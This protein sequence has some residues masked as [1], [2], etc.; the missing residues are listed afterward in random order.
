MSEHARLTADGAARRYA[1]DQEFA[2]EFDRVLGSLI[3]EQ[4]SRLEALAKQTR[5]AGRCRQLP[6]PDHELERAAR[7]WRVPL[8]AGRILRTLETL[9]GEAGMSG[10][11]LA[12]LLGV[13]E[14]DARLHAGM[15]LLIEHGR[16][17]RSLASGCERY[18]LRDR[19]DGC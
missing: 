5:V 7:W 9:Q 18:F 3:D 6:L 10:A 13:E 15:D 1:V 12:H 2:A 17:E 11:Q 4:V 19:L 14:A 8:E 16:V